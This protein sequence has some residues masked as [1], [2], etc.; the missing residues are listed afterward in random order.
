[1]AWTAVISVVILTAAVGMTLLYFKAERERL[2][3]QRS[4]WEARMAQVTALRWS[5]GP[6]R[7]FEAMDALSV[8]SANPTALEAPE[9]LRRMRDAAIA[10]LAIVDMRPV[11]SWQANPGYGALVSS[12][13]AMTEYACT[14]PDG[15]ISIISYPRRTP[16]EEYP[17][18]GQPVN[19]VLKFSPDGKRLA[20]AYGQDSPC[21]LKLWTRGGDPAPVTAGSVSSKAFDFFPDGRHCAVGRMEAGRPVLAVLDAESG[22]IVRQFPL[23]S[24]PHSLSVSR[25]GH[26]IAAS[27]FEA[28]GDKD[29]SGYAIVLNAMTGAMT[30]KA[31]APQPRA[32]A[33]SPVEDSLAVCSGHI[34][35]VWHDEEWSAEPLEL[36][37]HT[38]RLD[39]VAWSPDGRVLASQS[40]DGMVRLWDPAQGSA[41]SWHPGRGSSLGFSANGSRLG[42]L[43]EGAQLTVLEVAPGDVCYRGRGH[44]GGVHEGV[45]KKAGVLAEAE[46]LL[47]TCGNDGVCF[48]NREGRHRGRLPL[49]DSRGLAFSAD[50]LYTGCREGM[51]RYRITVIPGPE[52]IT[53]AFAPRENCI[54]STSGRLWQGRCPAAGFRPGRRRSSP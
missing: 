15:G 33:W 52:G 37:G 26:R 9:N 20:A 39:A 53:V 8:A 17:G 6:E 23:P 34:L 5:G 45:W 35:R 51:F 36:P 11:D 42:L 47:A 29:Q 2:A 28:N 14:G 24:E 49:P 31:A 16:L 44:A 32:L 19:F 54:R 7:R 27:L 41:L 10:C 30:G 38:N 48:W 40:W 50:S 25:D 22:I 12:N 46:L 4:S 21:Q 43:I 3:A 13:R 1:M 18:E